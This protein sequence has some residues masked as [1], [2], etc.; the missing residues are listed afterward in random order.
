MSEV[1]TIRVRV[2]GRV[3]GVGFRA[4]TARRARDLE[5]VGRVKNLPD[6]SVEIRA[7]GPRGELDK[8]LGAVRTGPS[9]ARVDGVE[10]EALP[11]APSWADF[12]VER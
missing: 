2:T 6:G 11:E 9:H 3:Q 5:V 7:V 4:F 10:E 1:E 8:L 12:R